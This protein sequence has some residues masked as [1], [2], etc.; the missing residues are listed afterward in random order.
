MLWQVGGS[1]KKYC[2]FVFSTGEEKQD[3]E[4]GKVMLSGQGWMNVRSRR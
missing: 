2:L 1:W 3:L 4:T